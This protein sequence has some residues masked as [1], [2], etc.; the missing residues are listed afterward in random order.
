MTARYTKKPN[1][2]GLYDMSGNVNEWCWSSDSETHAR[3]GS[4]TDV[5]ECCTVSYLDYAVDKNE[6]KSTVGFR[7][8][9]T[10]R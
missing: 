4:W 8:V 10:A 5:P 7:V 1:G 3:G 9:R 6:R 2:Y